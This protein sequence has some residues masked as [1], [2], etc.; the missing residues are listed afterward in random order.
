MIHGTTQKT[1]IALSPDAAQVSFYKVGGQRIAGPFS[2]GEVEVPRPSPRQSYLVVATAEGACPQY[3]LTS[4][5]LSPTGMVEAVL[6]AV[7]SPIGVIPF[8][9]DAKSGAA[10]SFEPNSVTTTL[11]PEGSCHE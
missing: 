8:L 4:T 5:S 7:T 10:F 6:G 2:P 9:I 11:A 1:T 3:W